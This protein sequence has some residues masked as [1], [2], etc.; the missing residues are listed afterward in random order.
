MVRTRAGGS[1]EPWVTAA[2]ATAGSSTTNKL[3]KAEPWIRAAVQKLIADEVAR[4]LRSTSP[5]I[6]TSFRHDLEATPFIDE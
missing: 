6:T 3:T 2:K 4:L 5:S 1:E